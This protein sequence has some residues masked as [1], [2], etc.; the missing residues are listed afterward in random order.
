MKH[1]IAVL[2]FFF[3]VN[4]FATECMLYTVIDESPQVPRLAELFRLEYVQDVEIIYNKNHEV[5]INVIADDG[6]R[7][8]EVEFKKDS[9]EDAEADREEIMNL[10]KR[11][12][13]KLK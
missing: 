4:A 8:I 6:K 13:E 11:C 5:L 12:L 1:L 9:L 10:S 3:S 7:R 2:G